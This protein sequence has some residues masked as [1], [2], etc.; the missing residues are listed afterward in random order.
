[1]GAAGFKGS[2]PPVFPDNGSLLF[3]MTDLQLLSNGTKILLNKGIISLLAI[4]SI[5]YSY[6]AMNHNYNNYISCTVVSICTVDYMTLRPH[7]V[8][9]P[10]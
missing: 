8:Y 9:K 2:W 7:A 1:M 4:Y 6:I 5:I 3:I 10:N